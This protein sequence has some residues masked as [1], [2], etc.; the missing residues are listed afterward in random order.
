MATVSMCLSSKASLKKE[1]FFD[2]KSSRT[3]ISERERERERERV[4]FFRIITDLKL[5]GGTLKSDSVTSLA[6]MYVLGV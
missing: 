6:G 1:L 4:H 5:V 3:V 2:A